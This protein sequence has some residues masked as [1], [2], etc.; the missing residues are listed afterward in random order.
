MDGMWVLTPRFLARGTGR[1]VLA[2]AEMGRL[3]Q[4]KLEGKL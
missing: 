2:L 1:M 4:D 3:G